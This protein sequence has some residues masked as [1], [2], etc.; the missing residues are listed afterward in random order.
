MMGFAFRY[1]AG[2]MAFPLA[3]YLLAGIRC[4]DARTAFLFGAVLMLLYTLL[5]PVMRLM[6]GV[7]NMLTLGLVWLMV[8]TALILL[9]A[10][11]LPHLVVVDSVPWAMAAA[12][13]V[14]LARLL[15]GQVAKRLITRTNN[16]GK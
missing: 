4:A 16:A 9:G 11:L 3:D 13:M 5:R 7:F 6:T 8:D 1:L 10:W 12:L 15:A 2:A 14:N